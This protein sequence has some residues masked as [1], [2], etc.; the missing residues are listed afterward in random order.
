MSSRFAATFFAF[1][2][3]LVALSLGFLAPSAWADTFTA[4]DS[5]SLVAAINGA[6]AADSR[7]TPH[8]IL[9]TADITVTDDLPLVLCN[10]TIDGQGHALDGGG[11]YRLMFVGVDTQTETQLAGEFP[12][13]PLGQRLAVTIQ[14]LALNNGAALGGNGYA[15]GGGGLGAGGAL[16]VNG[17]ADVTL[18]GVTFDGNQA[19]GGSGGAG[20]QGG[21][22]GGGLGGRGGS[23]GGGGIY[24]N[25]GSGGGGLMAQEGGLESE[26]GGAG[27]GGYTGSG[28]GL[29]PVEDGTLTLFGMSGPGGEGGNLGEAGGTNGG[30]GGSGAAGVGGGGGGGFGAL[31]GGDGDPVNGIDGDGGNGGFGGGGG[32]A[33]YP[34]NGGNGGFGGGGGGG[35][36]T[37]EGGHGLGG[38]GGGGGSGSA[39]GFGGGG[40]SNGS[41]GGFGG[42]GSSQGD[43]STPGPGGFGG[44]QGADASGG[45]LSPGG[46]GAGLG[47][48]VFVVDGGSLTVS[49]SGSISESA[50]VPGAAGRGGQGGSTD[51][52]AWGAGVFMQGSTGS[53][54]F[55]LAAADRFTL[56]DAIADEHG[57]DAGASDDQRGIELAGTGT[58]IIQGEHSYSGAT[59]VDGGVLEID[60]VLDNS[61]VQATGGTLDG[62]GTI[63]GLGVNAATIAPG[64]DG[65][66]YATLSVAGNAEF[67]AGST[68]HIAAD[69][70]STTSALLAVGG[71]ATPGGTLVF[72]FGGGAPA[73]GTRY[74]AVTAATVSGG[75]FELALPEGVHG[76]LHYAGGTVQLEITGDEIFSDGFD[77]S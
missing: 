61:S 70:T 16:F 63:A 19:H 8:T 1:P 35:G 53:V 72:D 13:S 33:V 58:L 55:D 6:N 37:G 60:G 34:G 68:L 77:G 17:A 30:G 40:G 43:A 47:G 76:V 39:G 64:T 38:F 66:P 25:G 45:L 56:S 50:V 44:G 23:G 46:G 28:G 21:A 4:G 51:G 65:Q 32:E 49:G 27:G 69:P 15:P 75:A 52:Q 14:N 31:S 11:Q 3:R 41:T 62:N 22:G 48:A 24:G 42:G 73:Q 2:S 74:T 18:R 59:L 36:G 9:L 10:T 20:S 67:A 5:A 7:T 26:N 12:D 29:D 57:S 71:T 54:T